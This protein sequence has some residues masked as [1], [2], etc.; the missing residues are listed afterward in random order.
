MWEDECI[1]KRRTGEHAEKKEDAGRCFDDCNA[2]RAWEFG[3]VM[4]EGG[5]SGGARGT[6][7]P[8]YGSEGRRAETRFRG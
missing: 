7:R 3:R 8:E 5:I 4:E 2:R 6:D 1:G